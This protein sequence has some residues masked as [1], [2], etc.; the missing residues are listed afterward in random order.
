[1]DTTLRAFSAELAETARGLQAPMEISN[2]R[3]S[4]TYA[5]TTKWL[6]GQNI[7]EGLPIF[8]RPT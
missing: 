3:L 6:G 4:L 5:A 1:M 2:Q 7:I 8:L